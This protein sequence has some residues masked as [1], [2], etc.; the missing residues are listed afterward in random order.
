MLGALLLLCL[1]VFLV[2]RAFSGEPA[3]ERAAIEEGARWETHTEAG[4]GTTTV[5]VRRIARTRSGPIELGRQVI[6]AIRDGDPEWETNY[7]TA[8]AQARSRVAA[9]EIESD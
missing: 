2:M 9:L 5:V 3:R 6:A 4:D 8:M 7:H 1:L